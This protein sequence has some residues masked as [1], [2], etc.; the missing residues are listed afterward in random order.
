MTA[1]LSRNNFVVV[2]RVQAAVDHDHDQ[3]GLADA[4]RRHLV[5]H[6]DSVNPSFTGASEV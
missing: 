1:V 4:E 3:Y 5:P 2:A 6:D